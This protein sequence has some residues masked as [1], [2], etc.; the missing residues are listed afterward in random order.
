MLSGHCG[1][2]NQNQADP[3]SMRLVCYCILFGE[4]RSDWGN[5]YGLER[6]MLQAD[7]QIG[8]YFRLLPSPKSWHKGSP[9]ISVTVPGTRRST[10]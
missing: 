2:Q 9:G 7:V 5:A 6:I 10:D 1:I 8:P 4:F 3:G